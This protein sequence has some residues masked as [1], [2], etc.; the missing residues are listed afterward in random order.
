MGPRAA[1]R[2]V[3]RGISIIRRLRSRRRKPRTNSAGPTT[4]ANA[5]QS[6]RCD[7]NQAISWII[8]RLRIH[9][10][11]YPRWNYLQFPHEFLQHRHV[12][13]VVAGLVNRGFSNESSPGKARIIEQ[14]A[15]GFYP[16][17]SLPDMLMTIEFRSARSLRVVTVPNFDAAEA[18]GRFQVLQGLAEALFRDDVVSGDVCVAGIDADADGDD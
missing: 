1:L 2:M 4:T 7:S 3:E 9:Q 10:G 12:A 5:A 17:G 14:G 15:E 6:R 11:K 16:D 8:R 18:D 13:A